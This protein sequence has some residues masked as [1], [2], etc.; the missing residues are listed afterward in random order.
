MKELSISI[1]RQP[2]WDWWDFVGFSSARHG[3]YTTTYGWSKTG[4][5]QASGINRSVG[6]RII[7]SGTVLENGTAFT[8]LSINGQYLQFANLTQAGD[9]VQIKYDPSEITRFWYRYAGIN[10]ILFDIN[11]CLNLTEISLRRNNIAFGDWDLSNLSKLQIFEI[12]RNVSISN[13]TFHP[14]APITLFYV[15]NTSVA[16]AAIDS[17]IVHA[18]NS[19]INNGQILNNGIMPSQHL[20]DEC[21]TLL[22]RGWSITTYPTCNANTAWRPIDPYCVQDAPPTM[23][24]VR[25]NSK[26]DDSINVGWDPATDDFGVTQYEV[27]MYTAAW[28][29]WVIQGTTSGEILSLNVTGL[30]SDTNYDIRVRAKDTIDQWSNYSTTISTTTD[31]VDNP[32]VIGQLRHLSSGNDYIIVEWDPATDDNGIAE[33]EVYAYNDF[34]GSTMHVG[35][36]NGI[37]HRFTISDLQPG[38]YQ[39]G[40]RAKDTIG[41]YSEFSNT[42]VASTDFYMQE[43]EKLPTFTFT[44]DWS[45][46][47]TGAING[48]NGN[49]RSYEKN[50]IPSGALWSV[51]S[52]NYGLRIDW[53]NSGNCGGTNNN[54]QSGTATATINAS[55]TEPIYVN[56]RGIAELQDTNFENMSVKIDGV[57]IGE[58]TSPGGGQ[59]CSM[60]E[61]VSTNY[62]PDG[63]TLTTGNH[64]LEITA[65]TDDSLYHVDAYYEFL[66]STEPLNGF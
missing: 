51:N 20:C 43:E 29:D 47:D 30:T 60:G 24:T 56:W 57:L 48:H 46:T 58:A 3:S 55:Q 53:E 66:F 23:N 65:T 50:N 7:R 31:T 4:Y 22:A 52:S 54:T 45:F 21:E 15:D 25:V 5:A 9:K 33:Y 61:I 32:P 63:Y 28:G 62:Y 26:T 41:Q 2:K 14:D 64:T 13:V 27:S 42:V 35:T 10:Q 16:T 34:W 59:G 19:G 17:I 12:S 37:T 6:A 11:S 8:E 18:F 39:I 40:V 49:Q 1:Y 44:S 36:T 38:S